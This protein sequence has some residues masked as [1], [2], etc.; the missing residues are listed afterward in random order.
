MI[1]RGQQVP[2]KLKNKRLLHCHLILERSHC[3]FNECDIE[4]YRISNQQAPTMCSALISDE[5]GYCIRDNCV[6]LEARHLNHF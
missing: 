1:G 4:I 5:N 2:V 6:P 3:D